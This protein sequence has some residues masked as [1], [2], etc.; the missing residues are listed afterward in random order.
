M[1]KIKN[2]TLLSGKRDKDTSVFG[3]IECGLVWM[4]SSEGVQYCCF[5]FFVELHEAF[6]DPPG[7]ELGN[8]LQHT[9]ITDL[10]DV[11]EVCEVIL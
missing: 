7:N 1:L 4:A 3:D 11:W 10:F 6:L 8:L 2:A 9:V 5:F